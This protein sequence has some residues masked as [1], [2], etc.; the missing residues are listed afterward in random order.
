[1]AKAGIYLVALAAMLGSADIPKVTFSTFT[2]PGGAVHQ[3]TNL[4]AIAEEVSNARIYAGFHYR[5]STVVGRDMGRQIGSYIV[6]NY[7]Q[8]R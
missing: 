5:T 4:D 3:F 8:A 6:Q 2:A 1:M 7:M